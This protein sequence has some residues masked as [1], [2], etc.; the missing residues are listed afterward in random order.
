MTS[1]TL[2]ET[3]RFLDE[4]DK[5][6]GIQ[7]DLEA[8]STA[9]SNIVSNPAPPQHQSALASALAEFEKAVT[10]M[11]DS[12]SP[13][14]YELLEAMG[15]ANFFDP[16]IADKVKASIQSNAMTPSVA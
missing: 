9:L 3:I 11:R 13:S 2:Y 7:P 14:Q 15:G 8:V 12:I 6:L 16:L 10:Q 4:L 5:K 1:Q